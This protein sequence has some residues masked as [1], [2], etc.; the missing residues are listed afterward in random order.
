VGKARDLNLN[1]FW[2]LKPPVVPGGRW[3]WNSVHLLI[4]SIEDNPGSQLLT[5]PLAY[6]YPGNAPLP[7]T[8]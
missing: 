6:A 1:W 7:K 5:S 2:A 4:R 8:R 3:C